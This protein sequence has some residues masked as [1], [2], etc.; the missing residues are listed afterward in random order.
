MAYSNEVPLKILLKRSA[1]SAFSNETQ[2]M[3]LSYIPD[4]QT[5]FDALFGSMTEADVDTMISHER[6]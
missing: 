3:I 4:E 1:F 6:N 5:A 2:G